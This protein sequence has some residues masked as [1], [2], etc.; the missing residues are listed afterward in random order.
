MTPIDEVYPYYML[1]SAKSR[2]VFG[3]VSILKREG[4]ALAHL[5]TIRFGIETGMGE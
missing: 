1:S 3:F 4:K 5:F 2:G